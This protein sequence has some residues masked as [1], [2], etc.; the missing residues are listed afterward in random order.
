ME[1]ERREQNEVQ[2]LILR[3]K[4][5]ALHQAGSKLDQGCPQ[6]A[7]DLYYLALAEDPLDLEVYRGLSRVAA[8]LDCSRLQQHYL[9][10]AAEL[11]K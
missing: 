9:Q 4:K 10:L 6:E 5:Q 2:G 3:E 8:Q 11:E 7:A 1:A